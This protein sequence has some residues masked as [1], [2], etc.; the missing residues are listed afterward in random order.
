MRTQPVTSSEMANSGAG[1]GNAERLGGLE[2]D[3]ETRRDFDQRHI[4][5]LRQSTIV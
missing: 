5:A 1:H 4:A 3:G 2:L